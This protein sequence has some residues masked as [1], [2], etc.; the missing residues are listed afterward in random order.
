[1]MDAG[2]HAPPAG[3]GSSRFLKALR[4]ADQPWKGCDHLAL[5]VARPRMLG[6]PHHGL[7]RGAVNGPS[8]AEQ[9]PRE[10]AAS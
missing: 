9:G 1:M 5:L 4:A 10:P 7:D 8:A 3:L 6:E 2:R